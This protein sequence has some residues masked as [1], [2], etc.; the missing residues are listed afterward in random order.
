[1]SGNEMTAAAKKA[2][3]V[4]LCKYRCREEL[5]LLAANPLSMEIQ[6]N[7]QQTLSGIKIFKNPLET[8]G[9]TG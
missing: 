3:V 9:R 8:A 6:Y 4:F 5:S 7:V 1:M 2:G